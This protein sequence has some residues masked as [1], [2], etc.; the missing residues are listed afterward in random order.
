VLSC[1]RQN[2]VANALGHGRLLASNVRHDGRAFA[3]CRDM[4]LSSDIVHTVLSSASLSI[5]STVVVAGL[6][7]SP[8]DLH[9]QQGNRK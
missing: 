3:T 9:P 2:L 5:G 8:G 7:A 6:Q 4:R 1:F